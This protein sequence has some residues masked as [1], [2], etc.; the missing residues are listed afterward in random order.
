MARVFK[1]KTDATEY[2]PVAGDTLATIVSTKCE[3][4]DPPIT[5]DEV[6]LFNW[7]TKEPKEVQRALIEL[8]GVKEPDEADPSKSKLDPA[9]GPGGTPGKILLPKV[10]KKAGLAFEKVHTLHVKKQKPATAVAITDLDKWFLPGTEE[11]KVEYALEGL[12]E[13]ALKVGMDVYASNYAKTTPTVS[14]EFV[15]YTY[16]DIPDIP[17]IQKELK[18]DADERSS[19]AD[20]TW[21]GESEAA[22]GILKPRTPKKRYINA[23]SAPYTVTVKY[24]KSDPHKKAILRLNSFW[25]RWT[26]ATGSRTV[27]DESLKFKWTL[28]DCPGGMQGHFRITDKAG[29][30]IW[31]QALPPSKCANGEWE[32]DWSADGKTLVKEVDMPYRVQIQVHTDKDTAPGLGLAAMHTDVRI[33]T[34]PKIGTFGVDGVDHEQEPQILPFAVAPF[35]SFN[36]PA[37]ADDSPKGR[38]LKLAAAGYHPGPVEDG[39]GQ[40]PYLIAIKEF[41]RDHNQPGVVPATR[42]KADGTIGADTK[43]AI[44][45]QAAGRR[46]LY[47]DDSRS[48]ITADAA[49]STALNTKATQIVAWIDDRHNHTTVSAGAATTG[50]LPNQGLEDYRGGSISTGDQKVS[51]DVTSV[52]R[53]WLPVEVGIPIMAKADDLHAADPAAPEV[54]DAMCAATGPIRVDWTFRDT[55]PE[56]KVDTSQYNHS[57]VRSLKYLTKTITGIKGTHNGKDAF[58]VTTALGGLRDGDYYK[59]LFGADGDSLMPWKAEAD[60]GVKTVCSVAHDDLGQDEAHLFEKRVGKA[61]IYLRP[62]IIGGD[63]FQFRA[64]VSFRDMP[65]SPTHP[66]WKVLRNRYEAKTTLPQAH[67]APIRMWRKDSYRAHIQWSPTPHWGSYDSQCAA[68]YVPGMVH[69]IQEGAGTSTKATTLYPIG[70]GVTNWRTVVSGSVIGTMGANPKTDAYRPAAEMTLTD[71]TIWPWSTAV[72]LG[73]QAVPPAG[74]TLGGY[75]GAFQNKIR[76]DTW[77]AFREPLSIDV[78]GMLERNQ[79]VLRG[80][81]IGEFKASPQYWKELYYCSVCN[82]DHILMELTAAGG[83]GIGEACRVGVCAGVLKSSIREDYKCD[84]CGFTKNDAVPSPLLNTACTSLCTGS[85]TQDIQIGNWFSRKLGGATSVTT[86]YSCSKCSRAVSRVEASAAVGAYAGTACGQVCPRHGTMRAVG[87]TRTAQKI[88]GPVPDLSLPS[89][90]GP[91]GGLFLDT[92]E[93]PRTYWAHEVAHHKILEHAGDVIIHP[94]QHDQA[95]NAAVSGATD[96]LGRLWDRDCIMSYINTETGDDRAYFCGK[97]LLKLRGWKIE[98]LADPAGGETG[99]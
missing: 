13:R 79:G 56:Y 2:A 75:E 53:P 38:K 62:S 42:I 39:E 71:D 55:A 17:I 74:T 50:L 52:P 25:P 63:G 9:R 26:G 29:K 24:Y 67:T 46:A 34:H 94:V 48:D 28:K 68:F 54:T 97:C 7:G 30:L 96:P 60:G 92:K 66:N 61:G 45:A 36:G 70:A 69:L 35:Y 41:Q 88:A 57:R 20:S 47:A 6:A 40:A 80:H 65:T 44:T 81:L 51:K 84:Q 59:A 83:S 31:L 76:N 78:I 11:C 23:A 4:A 16:T 22:E 93:G 5:N 12:K 73:V 27:V 21:K 89:W 10:W 64:Q 43:A 58:N 85:F 77:R 49:I 98:G 1:P 32:H 90:G 91:L 87:S 95:A 37:P 15:S 18:A 86:N 33:F 3:V 99:P 14:G 8:I 72:H 19:A 82:T